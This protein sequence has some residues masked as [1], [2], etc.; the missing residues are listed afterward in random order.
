MTKI[1]IAAGL[2]CALTLAGCGGGDKPAPKPDAAAT[3]AAGGAGAPPDEAIALKY[4]EICERCPDGGDVVSILREA[5]SAIEFLPLVG[6]SFITVDYFLTSA[7]SGVSG[8]SE[9]PSGG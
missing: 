1:W 2:A 6:G 4:V 3:P 8:R 7:I 9:E 5:F